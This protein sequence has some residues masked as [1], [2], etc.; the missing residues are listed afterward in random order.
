MKTISKRELAERIAVLTS[1]SQYDA[2]RTL[3]A[4][5]SAVADALAAGDR[6]EFRDFGV[7]EPVVRR[8]RMAQ[9][10]KTLEK[11]AVPARGGV[12]FKMGKAL[13]AR[14]VPRATDS[15]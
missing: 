6:L 3:E 10:P 7:L 5:L 13:A 8:P 14:I 4:V 15:A 12:R 2:A 1:T 9:N 11:V